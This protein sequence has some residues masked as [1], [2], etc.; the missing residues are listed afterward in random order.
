MGT[1]LASKIAAD[2]A[3]LLFDTGYDRHLEADHLGYIN[4]GQRRAAALKPDISISN[5][6][7]KLVEGT[8][9]TVSSTAVTFIKLIR[10]MGLDGTTPGEAIYPISMDILNVQ[11]PDWHTATASA[12]V[13]LYMFDPKDPGHFY[14]SPPQPAANQGY[15][16]SVEPIIPSN[17]AAIGNAITLDD[18]YEIALF[19]YD[20]FVAFSIDAK[21]SKNAHANALF[22]LNQFLQYILG[23]EISETATEPE[24]T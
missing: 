4:A 23:K 7:V 5:V 12:T 17:I 9:Q 18:I 8:K 16:E 3:K 20:L 21:Q 15:V 2:A 19:H 22:H 6:A 10:N 24:S 1:V 13:E 11:A 14:I